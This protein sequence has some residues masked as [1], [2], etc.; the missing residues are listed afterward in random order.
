MKEN[1]IENVII[2]QTEDLCISL[3]VYEKFGD[4]SKERETSVIEA[5]N[6]SSTTC[7]LEARTLSIFRLR[8]ILVEFHVSIIH[9]RITMGEYCGHHRDSRN[10]IS[11][12]YARTCVKACKFL[13]G[14]ER[15]LC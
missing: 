12:V 8:E 14:L 6:R 9:Y 2:R 10:H 4:E 5:L 11:N 7:R 13:P 3:K 15:G 1:L